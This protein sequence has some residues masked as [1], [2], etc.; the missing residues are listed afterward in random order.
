MTNRP[1]H[2]TGQARTPNRFLDR[3]RDDTRQRRLD[4]PGHDWFTLRLNQLLNA[5]ESTPLR[6]L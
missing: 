6:T 3:V 2:D 1:G 4:G 5:A